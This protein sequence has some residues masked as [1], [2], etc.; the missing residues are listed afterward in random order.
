MTEHMVATRQWADEVGRTLE[1]RYYLTIDPVEVQGFVFEVYGVRITRDDGT[2]T[3]VPGL[4]M[5]A[6]R[7]EK[8]IQLLSENQVGPDSLAD[9]IADWL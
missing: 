9:V 2:E 1:S 5:S 7:I 6:N 8:L 4:T 3:A